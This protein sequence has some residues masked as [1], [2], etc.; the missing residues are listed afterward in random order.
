MPVYSQERVRT[1]QESFR[2]LGY[3]NWRVELLGRSFN[4]FEVPQGRN[5]ALPCFALVL[6]GRRGEDYV[7]GVS[8]LVDEIF[9]PLWAFHEYVETVEPGADNKIRCIDALKQEI[10]ASR[11]MLASAGQF[12]RY[13][14]A[15]KQFFEN[16]IK[17]VR[18]RLNHYNAC[19]VPEFE[20]SLEHLV[21]LKAGL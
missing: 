20:E 2:N 3:R 16:I 1:A 8:D 21:L 7:I 14:E 4:F 10:D 9:R 19:V 11:V 5:P 15:R 12:P 13:V 17:Y 6:A 18:G